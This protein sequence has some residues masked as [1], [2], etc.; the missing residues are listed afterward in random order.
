MHKVNVK[1]KKAALKSCGKKFHPKI[2][3]RSIVPLI[4]E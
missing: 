3:S 1:G 2:K 4:R